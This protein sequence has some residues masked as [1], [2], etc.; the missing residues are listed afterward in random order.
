[1]EEQARFTDLKVFWQEDQGW[2]QYLYLTYL[3]QH[4]KIKPVLNCA[5]I[6]LQQLPSASIA[7]R[8]VTN[9]VRLGETAKRSLCY[10]LTLSHYGLR[11]GNRSTGKF[12]LLPGL[13]T[14]DRINLKDW[15]GEPHWLPEQGRLGFVMHLPE[16]VKPLGP[17]RVSAL[18]ASANPNMGSC[19]LGGLFLYHGKKRSIIEPLRAYFR[20]ILG[21]TSSSSPSLSSS[22]LS[23][24]QQENLNRIIT[25][26]SLPIKSVVTSAQREDAAAVTTGAQTN[27][28]HDVAMAGQGT[29]SLRGECSREI[30]A[31]FLHAASS[32]HGLPVEWQHALRQAT[33]SRAAHDG[34][35]PTARTA[36]QV[37]RSAPG[38]A[39]YKHAQ[40]S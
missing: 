6:Q 5:D 38:R 19:L 33:G 16:H 21:N 40:P 25:L 22:L 10:A 36:V 14:Q 24:H 27:T 13:N 2:I 34:G 32:I 7:N 3:E 17:P 12:C 31:P 9:A 8:A 23:L 1:M 39:H 37:S 20:G 18:P 15:P 4:F 11:A 35:H 30:L 28:T 26:G 29:K